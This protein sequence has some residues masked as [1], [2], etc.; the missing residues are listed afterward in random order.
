[1]T[2]GGSSVED[3]AARLALLRE[4]AGFTS[5]SAFAQRNGFTQS[6]WNH[7]ESGRRRLPITAA[8]RLKQNWRVTL[9]WIYHGERS[10]LSVEVANS[11]PTLGGRAPRQA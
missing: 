11:L 6:E 2:D 10:G 8:N 4:W 3:V 7:F 1:M 5:Q 9:D